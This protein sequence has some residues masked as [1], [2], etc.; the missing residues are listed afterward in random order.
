MKVEF[1][2]ISANSNNSLKILTLYHKQLFSMYARV[3][4]DQIFINRFRKFVIFR[5]LHF[6]QKI[7][8]FEQI[9]NFFWQCDRIC[10]NTYFWKLWKQNL[11]NCK[12]YC[13]KCVT[14]FESCIQ[15]NVYRKNL[16][17]EICINFQIL[18]QKQSLSI[19]AEK[20]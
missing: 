5:D 7:F 2:Y 4:F 17:T 10:K 12:F 3:R 8:V 15:K 16:W 9:R 14:H 6:I 19:K 18:N 1:H 11:Q 13:K 20:S